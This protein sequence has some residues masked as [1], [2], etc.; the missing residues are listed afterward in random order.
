MVSA[1]CHL[2]GYSVSVWE[3]LQFS[4][5]CTGKLA[6]LEGTARNSAQEENSRGLGG[7]KASCSPDTNTLLGNTLLFFQHTSGTAS[8]CHVIE[9]EAKIL[10]NVRG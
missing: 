8:C 3:M 7:E 6:T 5:L 1:T 2:V 10:R 4:T 9:V